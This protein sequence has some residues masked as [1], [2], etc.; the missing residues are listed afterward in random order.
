MFLGAC[1]ALAGCSGDTCSKQKCPTATF[2][3]RALDDSTVTWTFSGSP[4]Q[5]TTGFVAGQRAVGQCS[6]AYHKGLVFPARGDGG[7]ES[8]APGYF[9]INCNGEAGEFD[10]LGW[11]LG[12]PRDWSVETFA[13]AASSRAFG[14]D[15]I[16]CSTTAGPIGKP[17]TVADLDNLK[18]SVVVETATGVAASY[19]KLV[20]D[21]FVRVFRIELDTATATPTMSTGE[22]C[23]YP[24]TE[25]VSLHLTQTAGDY[26]YDP[27][28]PCICE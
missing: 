8:V 25:H 11:D 6:F 18:V 27:Q 24:V 10:L 3:L 12:D 20:T 26:V 15:C 19:P 28:A 1:L 23:D 7:V 21:D 9:S 22:V 13:V 4:S 14:T 17:C 16:S 2:D 5:T